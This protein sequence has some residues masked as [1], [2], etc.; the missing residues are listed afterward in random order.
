MTTA[1]KAD[2]VQ[3]AAQRLR[4]AAVGRQVK[5]KDRGIIEPA[6]DDLCAELNR[7]G[8]IWWD[9][10]DTPDWAKSSMAHLLASRVAAEYHTGELLGVFTQRGIAAAG[11]LRQLTAKTEPSDV[12]RN[13]GFF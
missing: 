4:I 5:D 6:F 13:K 12:V 7:D 11:S 9:G 8:A 3:L 10:D 2:I 1:T